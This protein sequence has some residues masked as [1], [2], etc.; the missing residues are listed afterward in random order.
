M[1]TYEKQ[2]IC[3]V[4]GSTKSTHFS[5]DLLQLNSG[6]EKI[7]INIFE[8]FFEYI[9]K[10]FKIITKNGSCYFNTEILAETSL[11]VNEIVK[12][13][14][15]DQRELYLN[16]NDTNNVL[17]KVGLLY[18]GNSVLFDKDDYP[19]LMKILKKIR[20]QRISS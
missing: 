18:Q 2:Q 11:I 5:D 1:F 16:I 3:F 8:H 12:S 17:Q 6:K 10:L 4:E 14:N 9:P 15:Y 7:K 19:I 20:Y 13:Y